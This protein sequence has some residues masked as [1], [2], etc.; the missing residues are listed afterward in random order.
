MYLYHE[1][2][3]LHQPFGTKSS[4]IQPLTASCQIHPSAAISLYCTRIQA[5]MISMP[6]RGS[7]KRN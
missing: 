2:A 5:M 7:L 4:F 1:S 6:L 3:V